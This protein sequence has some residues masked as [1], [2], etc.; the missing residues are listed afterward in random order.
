MCI[1]NE[2][3]TPDCKQ[4]DPCESIKCPEKSYCQAEYGND[5]KI[6]ASCQCQPG[7]MGPK[8]D[9]DFDECIVL[10]FKNII[11]FEKNKNKNHIYINI[12]CC[13]P[14]KI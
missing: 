11:Y 4:I 12:N 1:V 7:W 8:C 3:E 14:N 9:E 6:V 13:K 5:G 10:G 2:N